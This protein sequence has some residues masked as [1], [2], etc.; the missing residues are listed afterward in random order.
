VY[1]DFIPEQNDPN[2]YNDYYKKAYSYSGADNSSL[3]FCRALK[4]T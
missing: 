1:S 4:E 3:V 2:H